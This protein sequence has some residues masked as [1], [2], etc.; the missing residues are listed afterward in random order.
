MGYCKS[1]VEHFD[2]PNPVDKEKHIFCNQ[3]HEK[4]EEVEKYI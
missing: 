4:I 1:V 3:F 2:S